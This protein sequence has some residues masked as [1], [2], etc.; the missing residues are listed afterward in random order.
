MNLLEKMSPL[1]RLRFPIAVI[2]LAL[3]AGQA[4]YANDVDAM[5]RGAGSERL[6]AIS[7]AAAQR[8]PDDPA[9]KS[10]QILL[11]PNGLAAAK[12]AQAFIENHALSKVST[13]MLL[14]LA[15]YYAIHNKHDVAEDLL[16][17]AVQRDSSMVG[18]IYFLSVQ[19]RIS[20]EFLKSPGADHQQR[21]SSLQLDT[22]FLTR[23]LAVK[24]PEFPQTRE[25]S[26][27]ILPDAGKIHLQIGAF[28]DRKNA[29]LNA[30]FF[31]SRG[32]P[33]N[34]IPFEQNGIVIYK[35]WIGNYHTREEALAARDRISRNYNKNSFIVSE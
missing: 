24:I 30:E 14:V 34:I 12:S 11:E 33:V 7:H 8:F 20:G 31:K 35:V 18:D 3:I 6:R 4:I 29:D 25:S 2:A 26:G 13:W 1:S 23:Q 32:F 16:N 19:G 22:D 5:H 15:D 27:E 21:P 9:T 10:L 28:S 17:R